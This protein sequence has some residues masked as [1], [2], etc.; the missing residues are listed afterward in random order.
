MAIPSLPDFSTATAEQRLLEASRQS[1]LLRSQQIV[2]DPNSPLNNISQSQQNQTTFEFVNGMSGMPPIAQLTGGTPQNIIQSGSDATQ[3]KYKV[4]LIPVSK[5]YSESSTFDDE[6]IVF[7][8]MP[9]ISESRAATWDNVPVT[10]H[11][12]EILA[13]KTTQSRTWQISDAKLISRTPDEARKNLLLLNKVRSWVMPFYGY[14]TEKKLKNMLGAPPVILQLSAYGSPN[15][16]PVTVVLIDYN[17]S[18]P[19]DVDMIPC[20]GEYAGDDMDTVIDAGTPFPIL[21]SI[22]LNLKEIFSPREFSSFDIVAYKNGNLAEAYNV[23]KNGPAV[24]PRTTS[25]AS[26]PTGPGNNPDEMNE[27][28]QS[29]TPFSNSNSSPIPV[30]ISTPS[31]TD[32]YTGSLM[33]MEIG[34]QNTTPPP[35]PVYRTEEEASG[36]WN[37]SW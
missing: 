14:G 27:P 8:V 12:G 5:K 16:G 11:P 31:N 26:S 28:Q 36:G 37:S 2:A 23:E 35:S 13:Y 22:T 1:R 20:S 7:D 18:Y 3:N 32:G 6:G 25:A 21:S 29:P 9:V 34:P 17:F 33:D 30:D 10:H 19:N 4:K 24:R 15:I